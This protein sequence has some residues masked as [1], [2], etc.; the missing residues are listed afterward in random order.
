MLMF[1]KY[2]NIKSIFLKRILFD[3]C[4]IAIIPKIRRYFFECLI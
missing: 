1:S 2:E 4:N 3:T